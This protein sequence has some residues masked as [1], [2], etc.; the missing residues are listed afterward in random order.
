MVLKQMVWSNHV[1]CRKHEIEHELTPLHPHKQT[2]PWL[3][4]VPLLDYLA[5]YKA[6]LW[7][8]RS[9][10]TM[11]G[12]CCSFTCNIFRIVKAIGGISTFW[13][14]LFDLSCHLLLDCKKVMGPLTYVS[15][16]EWFSQKNTRCSPHFS[17]SP[18][19]SD[20]STTSD[21]VDDKI[22]TPIQPCHW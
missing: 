17:H 16:I 13:P 21:D 6:D 20:Q 9:T 8:K 12:N 19:P 22:T 7:Q 10:I 2:T 18:P 14:A 11:K 5:F 4:M 1:I 3:I 15:T